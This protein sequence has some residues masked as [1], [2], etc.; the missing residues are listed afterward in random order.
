MYLRGGGGLWRISCN[1]EL[2]D[3]CLSPST[4]MVNV[5]TGF[6]RGNFEHLGVNGRI[7]LKISFKKQYAM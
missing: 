4:E 1:E 2:H 5:G 7:V 3:L 6:R